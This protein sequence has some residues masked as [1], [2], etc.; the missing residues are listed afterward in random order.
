MQSNAGAAFAVNTDAGEAVV[1]VHEVLRSHRNSDLSAVARKVRQMLVEDQEIDPAAIV[2]LRP[3]GL[4]LTTS[5]KVQRS[6]CR[7]R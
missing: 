7:Q 2:L 1:V 6:L 3:G 5:G 4:P